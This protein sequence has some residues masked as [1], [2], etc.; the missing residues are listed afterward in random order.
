MTA[1]QATTENS[2]QVLI[3]GHPAEQTSDLS[4]A[5]AELGADWQLAFAAD[6]SEALRRMQGGPPDVV[7]CGMNPIGM[8]GT[9]LLALIRA[10]APQ[11]V[12]LMLLEPDQAAQASKALAVAHRLLNK[13]L[14]AEEL[15]E[16]VESIVDLREILDSPD[17]KAAIGRIERLPPPP[18]LYFKLGR[19]LDDPQASMA[20]VAQHVTE[21]PITAA[22][23]LRTS[24]SAY[25]SGGRA[26]TDVRSAVIRLGPQELQRMVLAAEVFDGPGT[27]AVDYDALRQRALLSAQ[28][29][30]QMVSP[31]SAE[32]A[33][34]AALLSEVGMLLPGVVI[35]GRDDAQTA[36]GPHYA[37]AGAYLLGLW[38]LPMP[39]VE[40]V[41]N[42]HR[43][44]RARARGF[45]IGGAVHVARA[46][47]A[48][49]PVDEGYLESIGVADRLPGWRRLA[50]KLSA[51]LRA[52]ARIA[53]P[54]AAAGTD[55]LTETRPADYLLRKQALLE[56]QC[57]GVS[58]TLL[59][60]EP[61]S[62][63]SA[64][65]A[66]YLLKSRPFDA[67]AVDLCGGRLSA[68]P[69]AE[70]PRSTWQLLRGGLRAAS[71]GRQA[72]ALLRARLA[73]QS[74]M[75]PEADIHE[76]IDGAAQ[77]RLPLLAIDRDLDQTLQRALPSR[78]PFE[79]LRLL[80]RLLAL[81]RQLPTVEPRLLDFGDLIASACSELGVERARLQ[82]VCIDER[83]RLMAHN[84]CRQAAA[85]GGGRVLAVIGRGHLDG[86][87]REI[88]ALDGNVATT[89][90][91][92]P[93][94]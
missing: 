52:E 27:L 23:A 55:P 73:I 36:G 31:A 83:D 70:P 38:G 39:I 75:E 81:G 47:A 79:R 43:P 56:L 59:G 51:R 92:D 65:A 49:E 46:L 15:Q 26:A 69:E 82:R 67:V 18:Q 41:A 94:L 64:E 1:G 57:N 4:R 48:G 91:A 68:H 11:A 54:A 45:W 2:V 13:P 17:L 77:R 61:L 87:A 84:L 72:L 89:G 8:T 5:L 28:L 78:W 16:A 6:A 76:A 62:P 40:A 10:R 90:A 74:G 53:A 80:W 19:T 21:D 34:T 88:R 50:A 58:Y 37:E 63:S 30:A 7:A 42:H 35:P 33:A 85:S 25:Y 24:N 20:T 3:I 93:P 12:R 14:R 29:A 86:M 66:E 44:R 32:M 9:A 22:K 60:A 71:L